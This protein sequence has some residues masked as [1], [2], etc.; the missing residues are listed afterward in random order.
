[1]LDS[2]LLAVELAVVAVLFVANVVVYLGSGRWI[3][4]V[5]AVLLGLG[6]LVLIGFRL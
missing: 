5:V 4:F 6:L 1:M 3:N 2:A